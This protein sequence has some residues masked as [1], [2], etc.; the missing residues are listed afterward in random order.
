MGPIVEILG[1]LPCDFDDVHGIKFHVAQQSNNTNHIGRETNTIWMTEAKINEL[2]EFH[3]IDL[4]KELTPGQMWEV[5][6][7][8][9][10]KGKTFIVGMRLAQN[11]S[12]AGSI[13]QPK[14][15]NGIDAMANKK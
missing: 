2:L 1:W 4:R 9:T 13:P 12:S 14:V 7:G 5:F 10:S 6:Y 3:S 8:S 15:A 11:Q